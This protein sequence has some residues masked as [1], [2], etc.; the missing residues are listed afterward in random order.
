MEQLSD[1][2]FL[3]TL[4]ER[5]IDVKAS[6]GRLRINAPVGAVTKPL[7]EELLR[8]KSQ[9]LALLTQSQAPSP[10]G[11]ERSAKLPLTYEQEAIWLME[12]FHPGTPAYS[13]PE[14]FLF[15]FPV[16][17]ELLSKSIDYL[18]QR[19][20]ILRSTIAE[21]DGQ[22][23]QTVAETLHVPIGF[24]DLSMMEAS[25]RDEEMLKLIRQMS[26]IPFELKQ[27]PLIRC[28]LFRLAPTRHVA[29][30][31][32]HHILTDRESMDILQYEIAV[33]Y[34]ALASGRAIDLPPLPIQYGD[35]AIWERIHSV[36]LHDKQ[37]EYWKNKLLDVP[38]HLELPFSRPRPSTQTFAGD[39]EPFIIP[40]SLAAELRKLAQSHNASLYML[41]LAAFSALLTRYTGKHDFCIGSPISGRNLTETERLIGLFVNTV[42][43]RCQP[44]S[45]QPFRELLKQVRDTAL[46]AYS[47]SD[48]P[49]QRL[50]AELHPLRDPGSSP[51]FQI[52]F[53]LDSLRD[54]GPGDSSQIDTEPGVAKFD[55]TLQ[56]SES[57]GA[58]TGHFE[59]RTDLFDRDSIRRFGD[60]FLVLLESIV[61]D[62]DRAIGTLDLLPNTEKR[63]ILVDWNATALDFPRDASIHQLFEQQ[64]AKTPGAT[65][66]IHR[67]NKISYE[68]LN[69]NANRLAHYLISNGVHSGVCVG[70]CLNRDITMIEA[71]LAVIK[72]GA[73]YVPLDPAY[74]AARISFMIQDSG[75]S[76]FIASRD[77]AAQDLPASVL[78]VTPESEADSINAMPDVNPKV[79]FKG[80][81]LAYVIYTSGSTGQPKGVAIEHHSAVSF[82]Y[83]AMQTFPA[84]FIEFVLAATSICFDLSIFEI[85]LPLST[86][87]TIVLA[88][89]AL[90]L[91]YLDAASK[92][93]LINTVPSTMSSLMKA[94]LVPK[95]VR[96]INLAGEALPVSLVRHIEEQLPDA[97]I[98][99]LYGPT[100]TTTYSTF[101]QRH[102]EECATIGRPIANTRIYLLD[103][104]LQ[105]VPVEVPGQIFIAGE[106]VA[107]GYLNRA[108]LTTE[109]FVRLADMPHQDRAYQTGDLAR[110]RA[111]GNIEYLGRIDQQ[112][113]IRGFRI[114]PGEIE[115]AIRSHAD[116]EDAV[117]I[118]QTD[119]TLGNSLAACV[120][121]KVGAVLDTAELVHW[122]RE[123]LP[124]HMVVSHLELFSSLPLT[125]NGK[126]DRK[127]IASRIGIEGQQSAELSPPRDDLE[128]QLVSIWERNFQRTPIGI[129]EDF[130][131]MGGHSLLALRVFSDIEKQLGKTLM[132]AL[133]LHAPT[134]RQL[135]TLIRA[136]D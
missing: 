115:N 136:Q 133:L 77:R 47:N 16:D 30:V 93:T 7:Q 49:F 128:R 18:L 48:I 45:E 122:Q 29:F 121:L 20:E 28:H 131:A 41:L 124:Q 19:H 84:A 119:A 135:A 90:E 36:R 25:Y 39:N 43:L 59:Y 112:V 70:I 40:T 94:D 91:P 44:A 62:P 14:A 80:D 75:L 65:A 102:A 71:M 51:F 2:E 1:L 13:I 24:T 54:K 9:L 108:E 35:Y 125:A 105:P 132:L 60:S 55:L 17:R 73:A 6:D 81:D 5:G 83:W 74:P 127:A 82:L 103:D 110:Y 38:T 32:V 130:F 92:I 26:R 123:M 89:N 66:I 69:R 98:F 11:A 85:F 22:A 87:N 58:I 88:E 114:E 15:E 56:L 42:I 99:D 129:D 8:R 104:C 3:R 23:Y 118:V 86:G 117:V 52:M 61:S 21:E 113:K 79:A 78:R 97:R 34:G 126:I 50:V 100:E 63:K 72:A 101:T 68:E 31:N 10:R 64:V 67:A 134:I 111:D 12:R 27:C 33:I 57:G 37:S 53:A 95:T 46:E 4:K 109:K 76:V 116:V 96:C 106:G 120:V 107:R